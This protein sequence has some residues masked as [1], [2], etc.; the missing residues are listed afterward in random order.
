MAGRLGEEFVAHEP[1]FGERA[2][3]M[4]T[5]L[6]SIIEP[7]QR[8]PKKTNTRLA[9]KNHP[10]EFKH[11]LAL[12]AEK[13]RYQ[14]VI[15]LFAHKGCHRM[16]FH[17]QRGRALRS[18]AFQRLANKERTE[19]HSP[20]PRGSIARYTALAHNAAAAGDPVQAESYHQRAEFY[21]KMLRGAQD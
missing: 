6:P 16:A 10:F 2:Y 5:A 21:R 3:K 1:I 20:D 4:M 11:D 17:Q 18:P 19:R 12:R 9:A 15:V 8:L 13:R 7:P 14:P